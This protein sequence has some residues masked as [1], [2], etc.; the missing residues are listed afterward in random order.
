MMNRFETGSPTLVMRAGSLLRSFGVLVSILALSLTALAQVERGSI[1]GTV[2]DSKGAAIPDATVR[3]VEESTNQTVTMQTDSAGEYKAGNLTPGSYTVQ[4][5]KA[6]FTSQ[7]NKGF[8]IQV[9]QTARLDVALNV[10]TV[11]ESVQVTSA[12]PLLQSEN[13]SVGQV[14]ST[15]AINELPLNGRNMAQLAII[16]PGVTGLNYAQTGTIAS[17]V[18]P[19]E[20]RPGGTTIEANGARD[21]ANKVLL[22]GIDNTEMIAETFIV[23]PSVDSMQEFA[24]LT[25]NVGAQFDRGMGAI[26]VTSTRAGSNEWHGSAYEF[27]RNSYVDSKNFFVRPGAPNPPY[28]LNDFGGRLGGPILHNKTFFFVNYEGYFERFASTLITS[29]PTVA[30]R[31][32]NFRRSRRFTTR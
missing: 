13:A 12:L 19:D 16:A 10:G 5:D 30:E 14:I 11:N 9:F 3:V 4:V 31:Q 6:G 32:G 22:D 20:L 7:V 25:S 18:R 21:N 23:R 26:V 28:R 2:T 8:I 15:R 29:V 27:L 24:V 17:G 1:T